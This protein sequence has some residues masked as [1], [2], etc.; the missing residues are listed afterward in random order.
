MNMQAAFAG[1]LPQ[2]GFQLF[3]GGHVVPQRTQHKG[4]VFT[5]YG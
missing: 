5:L 2:S 4:K 3:V 1:H